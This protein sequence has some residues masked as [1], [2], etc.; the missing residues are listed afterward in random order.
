MTQHIKAVLFDLDDTLFDR[1]KAVE[2]TLVSMAS[3]F[4]HLF[5]GLDISKILRVFVASDD[6]AMLEYKAGASIEESRLVRN[7][8]FLKTLG[9]DEKYAEA[10]ND[11]YVKIYPTFR[12]FVPG[13]RETIEKLA[14]SVKLGV[15][16]NGSPDV[17]YQKL[18]NLGVKH[19]MGCIIVSEELGIRKPDVKIFQK[20]DDCLK[21]KP[22]DIMFVGDSYDADIAGAKN[23]G[24]KACW[25][26]PNGIPRPRVDIVPD[27]EIKSLSQIPDLIENSKV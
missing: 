12:E 4:P 15:I 19:L 17:Q 21:E 18:E 27:F 23:A 6:I 5:S 13:A 25:F 7:R 24:L 3:E 14:K 2:K 16:T 11:F 1:N 10:L 9:R 22:G 20:A 26:N 8:I